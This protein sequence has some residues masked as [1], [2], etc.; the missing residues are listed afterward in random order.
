MKKKEHLK[1]D[2]RVIKIVGLSRSFPVF[3]CAKMRL[4]ITLD[5]LEQQSWDNDGR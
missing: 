1:I 4:V 2:I 3:R 5:L